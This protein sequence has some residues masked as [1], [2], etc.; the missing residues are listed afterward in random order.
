VPRPRTPTLCAPCVGPISVGI[1]G[2]IIYGVEKC[3]S[4]GIVVIYIIS[5]LAGIL[6]FVLGLIARGKAGGGGSGS[7]PG[8]TGEVRAVEQCAATKQCRS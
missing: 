1:L 8:Y 6:F 5:I 3:C 7:G 4:G 2:L